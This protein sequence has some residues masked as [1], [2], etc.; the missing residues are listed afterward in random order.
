M[1]KIKWFTIAIVLQLVAVSGYRAEAQPVIDGTADAAYGAA[2]SIQDTDTGFG[3]NSSPDPVATATG[4]SEIDQVFAVVANDGVRDRLY[5]TITGNLET[6]FNKLEVFIDSLSGVGQDFIDS[7]VVP[8]AVDAFCCG[9]FG[10]TDG[11]LQRLDGLGFDVGFAA[12]YYLTFSNG[13]EEINGTNFWA[14]N[15]HYAELNNG[16]SGRNVSAGVQFAPLG[17]PSVLRA[18]N[19]S[20]FNEDFGTDGGDFLT[21][22]QGFGTGATK[23]EGDAD[24]S[25]TVDGTDLGVWTTQYGTDRSLDNDFFV[26]F[27]GGPNSA[28]QLP[29]QSGLPGLSQGQLVDR[30]YALGAGGCTAADDDGGAGC[31]ARELEFVLPVDSNDPTNALNH[32]DFNNEIDLELAFDNSNI[33]GVGGADP[34]TFT[35]DPE[36]V[37]TGLEFSIPLEELGLAATGFSGDIKI[38]AFINGT[39]HDF[40]ANQFSGDGSNTANFGGLPPDLAFEAAGDQFVTV[41]VPAA[42]AVGAVP[43]PSSAVLIVLGALGIVTRRRS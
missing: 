40:V 24:N 23:S 35:G 3:D 34:S 43:E 6:N 29:L 27:D 32:R 26:P 33:A 10:T 8:A 9:G 14:I 28:T 13:S 15:A 12:D 41:Q 37:I 16:P 4:G 17:I 20:D 5:V 2:L 38:T 39:G 7:T 25:G 42:S 30:N 18:T 22:Q 19:A 31:I 21:W 1:R 11:A 36:N